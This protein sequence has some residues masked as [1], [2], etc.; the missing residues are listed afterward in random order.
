M[1]GFKSIAEFK[2][3]VKVGDTLQGYSTGKTVRVTAVG[4]TRF[5]YVDHDSR[6][7][8]EER[9]SLMVSPSAHWVKI[10]SAPSEVTTL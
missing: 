6:Y 1:K 8:L 9:V 2:R 5:L 10:Y 7:H 3:D 4:E